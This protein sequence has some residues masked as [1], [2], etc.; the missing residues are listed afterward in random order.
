MYVYKQTI[1][2][3]VVIIYESHWAA[4]NHT[5]HFVELSILIYLNEERLHRYQTGGVVIFA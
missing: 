2:F 4:P 1:T 3:K 5:L